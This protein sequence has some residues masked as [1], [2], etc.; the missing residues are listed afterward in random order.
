MNIFHKIFYLKK[1]F[2]KYFF[3][4]NIENCCNLKKN[5]ENL[6]FKNIFDNF[7]HKFCNNR[8]SLLNEVQLLKKNVQK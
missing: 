5:I 6:I 4:K 8:K 7:F 3:Y 2:D 1:T